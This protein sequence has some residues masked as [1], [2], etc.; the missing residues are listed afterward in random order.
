MDSAAND[1][2][3]TEFGHLFY[4]LKD[5]PDRELIMELTIFCEIRIDLAAHLADIIIARIIDPQTNMTYKKPIFYLIDSVMKNVGGP[6]AALFS[7]H[8]AE[9]FERA[10][11]EV[12]FPQDYWWYVK[13]KNLLIL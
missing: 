10:Y 8:I 6:Y 1:I 13:L 9:V 3:L 12:S 2:A 4:R 7:R 11:G 5:H